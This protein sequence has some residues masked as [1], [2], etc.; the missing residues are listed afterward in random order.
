MY[1]LAYMNTFWYS[2]HLP[3]CVPGHIC[4]FSSS[5]GLSC[6]QFLFYKSKQCVYYSYA[7]L[8]FI[9]LYSEEKYQRKFI[10]S[11]AGQEFAPH[12]KKKKKSV[13]FHYLPNNFRKLNIFFQFAS[14]LNSDYFYSFSEHMHTMFCEWLSVFLDLYMFIE[15]FI[16]ILLNCRDFLYRMNSNYVLYALCVFCCFGFVLNFL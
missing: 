10:L 13:F 8:S 9:C 14:L 2:W 12:K 3:L 11:P 16:F 15:V 7:S 6:F 4:V 1:G 5:W